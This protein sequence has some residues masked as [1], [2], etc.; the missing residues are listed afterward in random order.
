MILAKAYGDK[1]NLQSIQDAG[2][3]EC[4]EDIAE[5]IQMG[6]PAYRRENLNFLQPTVK[7]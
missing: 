1:A 3:V 4:I 6:T 7:L 2:H 5:V